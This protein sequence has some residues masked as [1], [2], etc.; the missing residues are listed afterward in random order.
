MASI[1]RVQ[2]GCRRRHSKEV[3]VQSPTLDHDMVPEL[4]AYATNKMLWS[5]ETINPN[6]KMWNLDEIGVLGYCQILVATNMRLLN[7]LSV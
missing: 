3:R 6:A 7:H 4:I 2:L 1:P 5:V